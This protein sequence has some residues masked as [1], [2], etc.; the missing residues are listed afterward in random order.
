MTTFSFNTH[1][2]SEL[3]RKYRIIKTQ[4]A[5][6]FKQTNNVTVERWINGNDL[7]TSPLARLC[8]YYN[9]DL[10]SF[11]Q[12]DGKPFSTTTQ[13]IIAMEEA[14]LSLRDLMREHGVE[15]CKESEMRTLIDEF[16]N[17]SAAPA[18]PERE[19]T[20]TFET[21]AT[22]PNAPATTTIAPEEI[23]D[24]FIEFQTK[25]YTHEQESLERQRKAMQAI[26]DRQDATIAELKKEL[27]KRGAQS[28]AYP[29][30]GATRTIVVNDDT[31]VE[32]HANEH[33]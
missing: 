8:S 20:V 12:H 24:R 30:N 17:P 27:R 9:L 25:A 4:V 32:Y 2:V 21:P 15:P 5:K 10:L 22:E 31:E 26:I 18:E 16:S 19:R 6:Q 14:G 29:L 33:E 7:Y 13:D 11:F 1:A 3:F 23:I 28:V